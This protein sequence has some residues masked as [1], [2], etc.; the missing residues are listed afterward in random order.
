MAYKIKKFK[1]MKRHNIIMKEEKKKEEKILFD[2]DGTPL[3]DMRENVP[4]RILKPLKIKFVTFSELQNMKTNNVF[5][6]MLEELR[7]RFDKSFE[8]DK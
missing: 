2:V 4:L 6:D 5:F 8:D 7:K 1:F 3:I